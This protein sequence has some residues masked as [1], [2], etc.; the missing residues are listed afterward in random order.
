MMHNSLKDWEKRGFASEIEMH[1]AA[2]P[3]AKHVRMNCTIRWH[4]THYI[5]YVR[6][7]VVEMAVGLNRLLLERTSC[8]IR[9]LRTNH[10]IQRLVLHLQV[11]LLVSSCRSGALP[12]AVEGLTPPARARFLSF[13]RQFGKDA[14]STLPLGFWVDGVPVKWD[15]SESIILFTL[16]FPGQLHADFKTLRIPLTM[17]NKKI[18]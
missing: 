7:F 1:E 15:R 16:N 2:A 14:S 3:G 13:C 9:G 10:C 18:L 12:Y 8:Q 17:I 6:Q 4:D 11:S 5:N